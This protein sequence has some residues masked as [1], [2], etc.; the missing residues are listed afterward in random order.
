MEK[1]D[2]QSQ[3]SNK[4]KRKGQKTKDLICFV[5]VLFEKEKEKPN[6]DKRKENIRIHRTN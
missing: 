4:R 1:N 2:D 6:V 3:F 5:E